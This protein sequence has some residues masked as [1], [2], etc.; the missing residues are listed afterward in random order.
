MKTSFLLVMTLFVVIESGVSQ[1]LNLTDAGINK[2]IEFKITGNLE[3]THY[4]KPLVINA[5]N[6]TGRQITL[7]IENGLIFNPEQENYQPIVVTREE[8]ITLLPDQTVEKEIYGM[9]INSYLNAP[10]EEL[11]YHPAAIADS[12]LVNL[13][14]W[15]EK[16]SLYNTEAQYAVWALTNDKELEE[17]AGFDTTLVDQL[18]NYV[19]EVTDQ[20]PPPPPDEDDYL[21]N[22]YSKSFTRKMSGEFSCYYYDTRSVSIAM[23]NKDGVVVRELYNN[24]QMPAGDHRLTFEFDATIYDDDYYFIRVIENGNIAINMKMENPKRTDTRG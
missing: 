10:D 17:I 20:E 16:D 3:S 12:N 11:T 21:R 4:I 24:P 18:V 8:L 22:Y 23:F 9:C 5:K 19:A 6:L 14:R 13:T 15:I 2:Q 1:V 7:K